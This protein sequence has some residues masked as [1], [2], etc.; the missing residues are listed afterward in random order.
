MLYNIESVSN[1][2]EMKGLKETTQPGSRGVFTAKIA[3]GFVPQGV[4]AV[5]DVTAGPVRSSG[6]L[7]CLNSFEDRTLR[8]YACVSVCVC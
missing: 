8:L 1:D 3:F 6:D 4:S 5:Y 2:L 7:F